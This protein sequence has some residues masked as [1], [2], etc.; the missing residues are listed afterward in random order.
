MVTDTAGAADLKSAATR[1]P[2]DLLV[3]SLCA[4]FGVSLCLPTIV[5]VINILRLEVF[6]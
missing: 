1:I 6:P 2:Q 4:L 3:V 5:I